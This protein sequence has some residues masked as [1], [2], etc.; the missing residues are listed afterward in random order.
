MHSGIAF[1][2]GKRSR[3]QARRKIARSTL[4]PE[5]LVMFFGYGLYDLRRNGL[6]FDGNPAKKVGKQH[7]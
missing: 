6:P 7:D 1:C 2:A 4:T 3:K 5:H